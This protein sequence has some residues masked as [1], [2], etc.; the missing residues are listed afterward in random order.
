MQIII[1]SKM[2]VLFVALAS[3]SSSRFN[4]LTLVVLSSR[5]LV[6]CTSCEVLE[7]SQI[8][9]SRSYSR[10]QNVGR[11]VVEVKVEEEEVLCHWS[12]NRHSQSSVVSHQASC[13]KSQRQGTIYCIAI[14]YIVT[15]L[16]YILQYN[17]L[18]GSYNDIA[19]YLRYPDIQYLKKKSTQEQKA[20]ARQSH[21]PHLPFTF[22][23]SRFTYIYIYYEISDSEEE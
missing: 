8:V 9:E 1:N 17:I 5:V 14:Y 22:T 21:A 11:T 16:Q 10:Q 6:L 13:L 12:L 4:L 15:V 2:V 20:K 18:R 19:I 3:S 23:Q 7:K